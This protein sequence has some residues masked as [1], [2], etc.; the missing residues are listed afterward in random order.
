M[1]PVVV[2]PARAQKYCARLARAGYLRPLPRRAAG[3]WVRYL[4]I[5]DT[6]PRPPRIRR[7]GT[8]EDA[9]TGETFSIKNKEAAS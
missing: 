9:N 7:D 8:V 1:P 6:G 2:A 4:L 3:G 5:R